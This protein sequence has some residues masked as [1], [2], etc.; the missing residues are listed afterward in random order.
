MSKRSFAQDQSRPPGGPGK[1]IYTTSWM[2]GSV[3]FEHRHWSGEAVEPGPSQRTH[4]RIVLTESGGTARTQVRLEGRVVYDGRDHPGVL[5]FI[6]ALV[7]RECRY[8]DAD[9]VFS[10]IWIAP[11]LQERLS[12]CDPLSPES[13]MINGSDDV[14]STLLVSLSREVVA[15]RVPGAAYVEHLAALMLLRLAD[16]R[17]R[18]P[19]RVRRAFLHQR[20]LSRVQEYIEAHLDADI[21]L[22]DLAGLLA[23]PIDTF[24]R[25][26]RATTGL[27]PY[28]Y[29]IKRRIEQARSL[30]CETDLPISEIA[31]ALGFS[32]QSH[33]TTT[34]RRVMGTTPQAYRMHCSPES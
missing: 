18:M 33:F 8:R 12:G 1:L 13:A 22:A 27:S 24:G 28:A 2:D 23:L 14:V 25:Q 26:F 11:A 6:P 9:L 5:T 19:Q 31:L 17:R 7:E 4:H 20:A 32:S 21:S 3:V 10:G 15:D 34:F 29:V 16:S 30:L